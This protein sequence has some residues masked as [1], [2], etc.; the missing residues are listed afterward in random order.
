MAGR[1][2]AIGDIHGELD[3]LLVLLDKLPALDDDGHAGL[4]RR[5]PR[6]RPQVG[7]GGRSPSRARDR[8]DAAKVVC[9]RGNHEDA[10]LR[11]IERGLGRV[12]VSDPQ[13]LPCHPALV[14]GR[15]VPRGRASSPTQR[16]SRGTVRRLVLPRRRGRVDARAAVL[17]RGRARYLR[18]RRAAR[19]GRSVSASERRCPT[20]WCCC[21]Y[22]PRA[23]SRTT[24]ASPWSSA[25]RSTADLPQ[26]LSQH[27]PDDPTDL[28]AGE[29]RVRHR[30]GLRK[31]RLPERARAA[32]AHGLRVALRRGRSRRT[33]ARSPR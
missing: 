20:R 31:R 25:T 18:P 4:R 17:L 10:W 14:H 1:T 5:L 3:T 6:S 7:A 19:G 27:T 12:R 24:A 9:L 22:A 30:H 26:E 32:L 2:F 23:S 15:P 28:F 13:W 21:G 33:K 8:E 11:V 29:A 16:G